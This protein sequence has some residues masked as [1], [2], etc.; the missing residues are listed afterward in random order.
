MTSRGRTPKLLRIAIWSKRVA[1]HARHGL[2]DANT[3]D[4][5]REQGDQTQE[6]ADLIQRG[7][8]LRPSVTKRLHP[9]P[10]RSRELGP[11]IVR[12]HIYPCVFGDPNLYRVRGSREIAQRT[13]PSQCPN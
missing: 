4:Q 5:Q 10:S 2:R 3:A 12:N 9:Y 1:S 6:G 11:K 13:G 8:K 7:P